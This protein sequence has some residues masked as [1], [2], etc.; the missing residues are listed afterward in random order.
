MF[1]YLR[2]VGQDMA[3]EVFNNYMRDKKRRNLDKLV[4]YARQL[5]VYKYIS[6]YVEVYVG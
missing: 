3:I 2:R 5:R 6:K 1:R 4:D